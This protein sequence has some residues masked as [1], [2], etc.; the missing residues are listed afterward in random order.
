MLNQSEKIAKR[1]IETLLTNVTMRF[2]CEQSHRE[3]DFYLIYPN[4]IEVPVEVTCSTRGEIKATRKEIREKGTFVPTQKCC[5]DWMILPAIDA[6]IN[7]L[8]KNVDSYLAKIEAAG[9]EKFS[10]LDVDDSL[11]VRQIF[12]DLKIV[13]G[14]VT[15]WKEPGQI[16]IDL[17]GLSEAI[18]LDAREVEK[19]VKNEARKQD[20]IN[21]LND[22]SKPERHLFVYIDY[23]NYPAWYAINEADPPNS[24]PELPLDKM[25]VWAA[26]LTRDPTT[27]TVWKASTVDS[28]EN[29]GP[30]KLRA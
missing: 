8:R 22:P 4:G 24:V 27:C 3:C 19:A 5:Q 29:L 30:V 21:N 12:E 7:K 6:E 17:P 28:W 23:D 14:N 15:K 11:A 1:V 25:F 10:L 13:A 16:G 18:K 9:L 26:A 20:N 2:R